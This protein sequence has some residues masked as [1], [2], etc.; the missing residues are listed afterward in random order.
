MKTYDPKL[1]QVIVNGAVISGF[2]ENTVVRV[3][4]RAEGWALTVGVDGEGTRAKS[5]DKSGF[6]EIELMQSS[7]SNALLSDLAIAD[8]LENAGLV[9]VMVKDGSGKSLHLA[10]QAFIEKM[11]DAEYAKTATGRVWRLVTDN[12]QHFNGGN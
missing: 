3:G 11:P 8:E 5:N 1:V 6:I 9:A 2:A 10:E 7:E 12:L 4:R